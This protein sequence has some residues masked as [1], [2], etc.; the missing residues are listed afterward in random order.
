[1]ERPETTAVLWIPFCRSWK[2]LAVFEPHSALA[3]FEPHSSSENEYLSCWKEMAQ[4]RK[5]TKLTRWQASPV[6]PTEHLW[7]QPGN[8]VLV[9]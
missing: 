4:E 7:R 8:T 9:S 6:D 5:E 2:A 1:M 3:V